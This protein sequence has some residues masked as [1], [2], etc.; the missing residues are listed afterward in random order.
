M[1]LSNQHSKRFDDP[2]GDEAEIGSRARTEMWKTC[3]GSGLRQYIKLL[4]KIGLA[5]RHR[6]PYRT[7][8]RVRA[9]AF[10][11]FDRSSVRANR[12]FERM[13]GF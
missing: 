4:A 1:F 12:F 3:A 9:V 2:L 11:S 5:T 13:Q 10:E 7:D 8:V 6:I